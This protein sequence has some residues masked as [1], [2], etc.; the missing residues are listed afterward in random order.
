MEILAFGF[1]A[2][3][4]VVLITL[5]GWFLRLGGLLSHDAIPPLNKLFFFVL[6]PC[7]LFSNTLG[8]DFYTE[9][10]PQLALYSVGMVL[11]VF[12][13]LWFFMAFWIKD[14]ELLANSIHACFRSN[15]VI[16]AIPM[17]SA[18][19]GTLG[20]RTISVIIPIIIV[21]YN[22]LGIVILWRYA[23]HEPESTLAATRKIVLDIIKN[24]LV[25]ASL[26]GFILSMA[27]VSGDIPG[28]L[29]SAVYAVGMAATPIG[30]ILMGLQLDFKTLG[31]NRKLIAAICVVRLVVVPAVALIPAVLFFGFSGVELAV[32]TI[33]FGAP[34]PTV[35]AVMAGIY[36]VAPV[37]AAQLVIVTTVFSAG[38]LLIIISTLRMLALL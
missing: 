11:F 4:P 23:N 3:A 5:L 16:Y 37:F 10:R 38:T 29:L 24:P 34:S 13:A 27:G 35:A 30:L 6:I 31:D 8:V 12:A 15:F 7:L 17:M 22:I 9:F 28:F 32:L 1:G 36:N 2:V 14:K 33:L 18:M 19:F 26:S 20:V 25:L 21:L